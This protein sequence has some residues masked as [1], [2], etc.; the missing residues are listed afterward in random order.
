M[1]RQMQTPCHGR[2]VAKFPRIHQFT[3]SPTHQLQ[4]FTPAIRPRSRRSRSC[5]VATGSFG[6]PVLVDAVA[7]R[8]AL[9][10]VG[11]AVAF[12]RAFVDVRVVVGREA[13]ASSRLS[14][15]EVG[16]A[17]QIR[18][19]AELAP[20]GY[21]RRMTERTLAII[22][23]DAV[24]RQL[25]GRIHSPHRGRGI[26]DSCHAAAAPVETRRPRGSTPCTAS[27]RSSRSLTAFMSSG[28][29]IVAGSGGA[30]RHQEVADADGRDRPGQGRRRA[31]SARS[32]RQSIE[33]NA[34][35]GS[36]APETAAYEIG[37]FFPGIDLI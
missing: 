35:H 27:V 7:V 11:R 31:R 30:G 20:A 9:L 16:R 6:M 36:D 37:Y 2:A 26:P 14:S 8:V 24:E 28:P 34:T 5:A 1:P 29:A 13:V 33:R 18:R 21:N 4:N 17:R 12:D 3:K 19:I 15:F 22:K 32:S 10:F 23:P 25:A